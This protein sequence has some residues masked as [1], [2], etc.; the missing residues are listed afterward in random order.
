MIFQQVFFSRVSADEFSFFSLLAQ[1]PNK[2][3]TFNVRVGQLFFSF[4]D[5]GSERE[6]EERG[7]TL[8]PWKFSLCMLTDDGDDIN[9]S[10]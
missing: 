10:S 5:F 3:A 1:F 8:V 2:H 6:D 4:L 7:K 9:D